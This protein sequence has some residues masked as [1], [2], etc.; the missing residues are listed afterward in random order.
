M[1]GCLGGMLITTSYFLTAAICAVSGFH[2]IGSVVHL[3]DANIVLFACIGLV[4]LALLN[5]VGIRESATVALVMALAAL[6]VDL[7]VMAIS[8]WQFSPAQW[9][10]ALQS[11]APGRTLSFRELL[12]GFNGLA[13]VLGSGKHQPA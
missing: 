9:G 2:Y 10:Q 4:A 5:I 8:F 12:V 7:I 1:W 6:T 13:G 3:I 11:F